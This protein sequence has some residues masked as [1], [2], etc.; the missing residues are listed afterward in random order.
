[1]IRATLSLSLAAFALVPAAAGAY[2]DSHHKVPTKAEPASPPL[3]NEE[4]AQQILDRFTFGP[5]PGDV[6]A[7]TRVGWETWFEQQLNP[8]SIPDTDLEKRLAA[9]A[10]EVGPELGLLAAP[11]QAQGD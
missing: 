7:V 4:K 11:S 1:M 6:A 9:Y 10:R 2:S 8:D 3:T 5:R